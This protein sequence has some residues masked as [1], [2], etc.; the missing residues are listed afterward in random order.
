MTLLYE[1]LADAFVAEGVD[2]HFTL[3][4]D[5]NMHLA[6]DLAGRCGVRT[7]HTRHEHAAVAMATAHA[8]AT[9]KVGTASVTMGPGFAQTTAALTTAAR[10]RLPLV[11]FAGDTPTTARWA[12]QQFDQAPVVHATGSRHVPLRSAAKALDDMREAFWF[13]RSERRPVVVS[14]PIDLQRG[15]LPGDRSYAAAD[16]L[17]PYIPPPAA[18]DLEGLASRLDRAACPIFIAGRGAIDAGPDIAELARRCGAL[19]S[20]TLPARGLFDTVEFSLGIAGGFATDVARELFAAC[21]LVVAFGASLG[22]H[23]AD[24]GKLFPK[25]YVIQVDPDPEGYRQ[26]L[27]VAS[28]HLAADAGEVARA[29][30]GLVTPKVGLRTE[31][32]ARYI[33]ENSLDA[34]QF[35]SDP[36]T[37][38]PRRFIAEI[39]AV[40]PNDWTIIA[41]TGHSFYFSTA[42]TRGRSPRKFHSILDFGAIGSN[43]AYAIGIAAGQADG[44]V[45]LFD[46]DGSFLM[47]I[48]EL[49]TICRHRIRLLACVLNDGAY[50]AELHKLRAE[51]V[52]ASATVFGRPPLAAVARGFGLRAET[53]Q[54]TDRLAQLF[55]AHE[56]AGEAEVW[57]VHVSQSVVSPYYRR[58]HWRQQ[59][60]AAP[61]PR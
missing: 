19:L 59:K 2:L 61:A 44:K 42:L 20:T 53:L 35:P 43:L 21:D 27:R 54:T 14:A 26:G 55:E 29:L 18:G 25:A 31:A 7:I 30:L 6:S 37:V 32:T 34:Y 23:T 22:H 38:D 49:E 39:D 60:P 57:D 17:R 51:G 50:G 36:G 47:Q 41:S 56:A 12:L 4:G 28:D 52:D 48:Q 45:L 58:E 11:M 10:A 40:V 16:L 24:G 3:M 15:V 46:G 13:A 33:T 8:K 5:G 1:A 9:G